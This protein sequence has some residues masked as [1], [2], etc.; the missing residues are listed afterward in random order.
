M[1][2]LIVDLWYPELDMAAS[3]FASFILS[4]LVGAIGTDGA[5]YNQSTASLAMTTVANAMTQ[6]II[7][8]TT[9]LVSY[10]GT[11]TSTPPS[12]D[13]IVTDTFS[14]VGSIAP[15]GPSNS[16]DSWIRQIESNIISGF[17]LAPMG[18]AGVVFAQTPFLNPGIA[19]SQA[20]L[21][22]KHDISDKS[23]QQGVWEVVCQGIMDWIN[24]LAFNSTPGAATRPSG[25]STGTAAIT[26]ITII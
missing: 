5:S 4:Q 8:N 23:P 13:P 19:T 21:K 15:T 9:V 14:I 17:S 25:P 3:D 16:F 6:Y 18:N 7:T 22:A 2:R 24:G 12:P 10:V 20:M 11:I 1:V 26:K